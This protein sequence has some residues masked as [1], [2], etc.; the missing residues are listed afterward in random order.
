MY[1]KSGG[2][3]D[4]ETGTAKIEAIKGNTISWNQ[5]CKSNPPVTET[6]D[7]VTQTVSGHTLTYTG[8]ASGTVDFTLTSAGIN[9]YSGHKYVLFPYNI[10]NG[11]AGLFINGIYANYIGMFSP[12]NNE[13][14]RFVMRRIADGQTVN[15]TYNEPILYDLTL[16]YGAGN[17]P[18]SVEQFEAD[19]QRWFGKTLT[20]EP[21]DAGSLRN[22]KMSAIKTTGFNQCDEI[23]EDGSINVENGEK[24]P[25]P[26]APTL[27]T[28]NFQRVLPNTEYYFPSFDA[29]VRIAFY[30][31]NKVFISGVR[32][33]RGVVTT[34]SNAAYTM[35]SPEIYGTTY[36]HNIC[37]NISD[38]SRN[39]TYEPYRENIAQLPITTLTGKLNGEG[40][41]V[42]IFPDGMKSAGD[43]HDEIFVDNGVVKAIK[44]VGAVDLGSVD[45][46]IGEPALST[47]ATPFFAILPKK[48]KAIG[49]GNTWDTF[50]TTKGY[51]PKSAYDVG[52]MQ[53]KTLCTKNGEGRVLIIGDNS[54]SSAASFKAAM[55]G[56]MLY[57]ELE[58]PEVYE[59][60]I[61]PQD[62][63]KR[64]I[65]SD[66]VVR[67]YKGDT[68]LWEAN[69]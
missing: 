67:V 19:Y 3:E 63:Q 49:R 33:T 30:D 31:A 57:Y 61:T 36:N 4:I 53:D 18:T 6:K 59:L 24:I 10:G 1:R 56:V 11:N 2:T 15:E 44:R 47:Y 9:L 5:L 42:T 38:T 23:F 26:D 17:E 21:Y 13:R 41:S 39:R 46:N 69:N 35:Y 25:T 14:Y 20:Y 43:V 40:E 58:T 50:I 34:P 66:P 54:Y 12:S 29:Y 51:L 28:K 48:A 52:Y 45:W 32:K 7:G 16:I 55:Q 68:L 65:G 27:R 62:L 64:Y 37:I 60:D 22:V 8:R